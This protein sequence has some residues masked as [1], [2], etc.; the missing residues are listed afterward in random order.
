M[1]NIIAYIALFSWP[2]VAFWLF[3]RFPL[4]KA[5]ILS[6]VG[7][8]LLLPTKPSI[9]LPLLPAFDKL[10]VPS[11]SALVVSMLALSKI[12]RQQKAPSALARPT[13]P[14]HLD[15]WIPRNKVALILMALMI[16]S[17]IGT[18]MTNQ[19]PLPVG[20]FFVLP[21]MGPY[22]IAASGLRALVILLPFLLARRYLA[23]P[24]AQVDLLKL[25]AVCGVLYSIPTLIEIRLSPQLN[26]WI[27][28]YFPHKFA[29]HIRG[30]G[31]RPVVFLQHGLWLGIFL[32][33]TT[34][35]A[36]GMWRI[37][38]G[39]NPRIWLL[40]GLWMFV[41]AYLSKTLGAFLIL[42]ILLPILLLMSAR[43]Q[44][45]MTASIA[46]I[47]LSYPLLRGANIVPTERLVEIAEAISPERAR[48]LQ[49]RFTN[50]QVFLD[51]ANERP[52]FG[53]GTWNR[54]RVYDER[55]GRE[56]SRASDGYWIIQA[57]SAG[58]IGYISYVGLLSSAMI[59]LAMRR[60]SLEIS[61]A[62]VCLAVLLAANLVDSIPNAAI[63][64]VTWLI[65]GAL[66]GRLEVESGAVAAQGTVPV[67]PLIMKVD[68]GMAGGAA[69][70]SRYS[71][72]HTRT[73]EQ[74]VL[75]GKNPPRAGRGGPQAPPR[76]GTAR[77]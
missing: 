68:P 75:A 57:G 62:T 73:E 31:F 46:V 45:L 14:H 25:L 39:K 71:H 36:F 52:L 63:T 44:L 22:D 15:G 10:L 48:S 4:H 11:L 64:P 58:W 18:P 8:Y 74:R 41:V 40:L 32:C 42:I 55:N 38:L 54:N 59:I 49:F 20:D 53:W 33:M 37:G 24:D 27:Y 65:A 70:L 21:A 16:I 6:I 77:T 23:H 19:D 66:M 72:S 26:T 13:I 5:V 50:E 61:Q 7:G 56:L 76:R 12:K 17:A 67:S 2:V 60:R 3:R 30:D 47:L 43:L 29:Q 34:L 1:P 9:D 28:G 35:A 69:P 51:K